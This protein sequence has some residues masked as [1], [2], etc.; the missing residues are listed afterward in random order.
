MYQRVSTR[1][2]TKDDTRLKKAE[3]KIASFLDED[4]VKEKKELQVFEKLEQLTGR[5]SFGSSLSLVEQFKSMGLMEVDGMSK[6][7]DGILQQDEVELRATTTESSSSSDDEVSDE[8]EEEGKRSIT[9]RRSFANLSKEDLLD[10]TIDGDLSTFSDDVRAFEKYRTEEEIKLARKRAQIQEEKKKIDKLR[11][12]LEM[13]GSS[14]SK[15]E[16]VDE[17]DGGN[18][19]SSDAVRA[20]EKYRSE[21]EAKLS[22][23]RAQIQEDKRKIDKL[24]KD[25]EIVRTT[26]AQYASHISQLEDKLKTTHLECSKKLSSKNLAL[27]KMR[28]QNEEHL[29]ENAELKE[30]LAK[31]TNSTKKATSL[32]PLRPTAQPQATGQRS[33]LKKTIHFENEEPNNENN[34]N[35]QERNSSPFFGLKTTPN[36][37][38]SLKQR[39]PSIRKSVKEYDQEYD[40]YCD[41]KENQDPAD[42]GPMYNDNN[43]NAKTAPAINM[44]T[45][46]SMLNNCKLDDTVETAFPNGTRKYVSKTKQYTK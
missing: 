42:D 2:T 29:K 46:Q 25:M 34:N 22:R 19:T 31:F 13:G 35:K 9:R 44:K 5:P 16:P 37:V 24:K 15:N 30:K 21:E 28:K 1:L 10:D 4:D 18:S 43:N 27:T 45:M 11:K 26:N 7:E 41:T 8:E 23:Q 38:P 6:S 20:F 3:T 40:G 14:Q 12:E 33:I 39:S 36:A 32:N 17:I